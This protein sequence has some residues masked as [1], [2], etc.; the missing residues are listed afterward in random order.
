MKVL[1]A[2]RKQELNEGKGYGGS[3]CKDVCRLMIRANE[4]QGTL[5]MTDEELVSAVGVVPQTFESILNS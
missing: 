1:I 3:D 2:S 5:S 4:G